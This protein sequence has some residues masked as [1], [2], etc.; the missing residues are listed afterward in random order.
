MS[1]TQINGVNDLEEWKEFKVRLRP[2]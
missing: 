2:S 1:R